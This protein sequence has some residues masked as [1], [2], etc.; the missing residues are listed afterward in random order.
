MTFINGQFIPTLLDGSN[1]NVQ[2]WI[3]IAR[4]LRRLEEYVTM[5]IQEPELEGENDA[6]GSPSEN[7]DPNAGSV[8]RRLP[9]PRGSLQTQPT[10]PRP[11]EGRREPHNVAEWWNDGL[12]DQEVENIETMFGFGISAMYAAMYQSA[13]ASPTPYSLIPQELADQLAEVCDDATLWFH[14]HSHVVQLHD[15]ELENITNE[16][17]HDRIQGMQ[18]A[19]DREIA[20]LVPFRYHD[21]WKWRFDDDWRERHREWVEAF[22]AKLAEP[23][24][25]TR[26]KITHVWRYDLSSMPWLN[27]YN[28]CVRWQQIWAKWL[29]G[30]GGTEGTGHYDPV[31]AVAELERRRLEREAKEAETNNGE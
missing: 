9:E 14:D 12:T 1:Y 26:V 31:E 28:L 22:I 20:R 5:D 11:A 21:V 4:V 23:Q 15:P 6:D 25:A 16:Q 19:M 3:R 27:Q 24:F 13:Y 30:R 29:E 2:D 17:V 8:A 18:Y 7:S 10:L